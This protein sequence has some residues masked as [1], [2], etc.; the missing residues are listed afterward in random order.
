MGTSQIERFEINQWDWMHADRY[1][2]R[3]LENNE[4]RNN[5]D[6]AC[7]YS[8]AIIVAYSRPFSGNRTRDDKKDRAHEGLEGALDAEHLEVH[9]RVLNLRDQLFAHSD[10]SPHNVALENT[11]GGGLTAS[12]QDRINPLGRTD[13]ETLI[14]NIASFLKVNDGLKRDA[15]AAHLAH[16]KE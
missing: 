12:S 2:R 11:D 8:T 5:R 3:Y 7:A 15:I 9:L 1:C 16:P 4:F 6:D 14:E 13:V 10:A